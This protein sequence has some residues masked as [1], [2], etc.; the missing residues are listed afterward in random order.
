M[1]YQ[2]PNPKAASVMM[3]KLRA[4]FP[5]ANTIRT[6][7][8]RAALGENYRQ[9]QRFMDMGLLPYIETPPNARGVTERRILITPE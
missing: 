2:N 5:T 3:A 7:Q 8:A 1:T 4:A 6:G 9:I